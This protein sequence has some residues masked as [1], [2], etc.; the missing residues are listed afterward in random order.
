MNKALRH[1]AV[2]GFVMFALLFASTSHVQFFS[3][4]ALNENELNNRTFINEISR[5]RGP[6]L[7]DGTPVAYSV[8]TD[9][10]YEFHRTYGAD[11]LPAEQYAS[12]T[13]FFSVVSGA[14]GLERTENTLLNGT[15]DALFYDKVRSSSPASSPWARPSS[16]RSTPPRRTPPGR[17]WAGRRARSPRSTPAPVPSW[18]WP[19]PRAGTPTRWRPTTP[20]RRR[21]RTSRS[22]RTRTTRRS[23][24]R[25]AAICTR[26]DPR[27]RS[28]RPR[29]RSSPATTRRTRSWTV[30]R[31]WIC[32]RPRRR[33]AT[34]A[35]APAGPAT[36]S[37]SSSPSSSPATRPSPSWAWTWAA[38]PW[39]S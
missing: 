10:T 6:I 9:S 32:R 2:V 4:Q 14:S 24:G 27:S 31:S 5:E 11:G 29:P 30:R 33:S 35:A 26:R 3:A 38:T 36:A 13:G 1:V 23:T 16:S 34:P 17:A 22:S 8:P 18:H 19:R 37:P 20:R 21:R 12:L 7:V 28:S 15:D 25:S 39:R